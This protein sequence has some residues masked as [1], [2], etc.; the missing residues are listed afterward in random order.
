MS[1]VLVNEALLV[2]GPTFNAF[3]LKLAELLADM[4]QIDVELRDG[5]LVTVGS[6]DPEEEA[7]FSYDHT[8]G[9][10]KDGR[11]FKN[12]SLDMIKIKL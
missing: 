6:Y 12:S 4:G 11:S 2:S 8:Y 1:N 3:T 5:R 10:R 9:W 7:F